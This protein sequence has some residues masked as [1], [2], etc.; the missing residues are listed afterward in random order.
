MSKKLASGAET[1]VLDVKTGSGAFMKTEEDSF[2]L[3]RAMVEIGKGAGRNTVA[4]ISDM[5]QPLGSAVGNALEVKEAIAVLR[6]EGPEDVL[7]LCL[8]LGSYMLL[9]TEAANSKEKAR[10]LLKKTIKDGSALEKFADFVE[11]QGGRREEVY[12]PELLQEASIIEKLVSPSEGYVSAM[13]NQEVGKTV[14]CLG[15]G[16]ETKESSID[17]SVGLILHKKKGDFVKKGEALATIYASDAEK[18]KAAKEYFSRVYSFSEKPVKKPA[19][20]KGVVE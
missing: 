5:D 10:S 13:K 3:A 8:E 18:L 1:I 7:E 9:G 11:A 6:G 14:L 16:R 2:A 20:I 15:G 19:L 17:L 4:V 12:H